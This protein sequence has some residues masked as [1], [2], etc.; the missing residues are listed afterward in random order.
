MPEKDNSDSVANIAQLHQRDYGAP[1]A[2]RGG[3]HVMSPLYLWGGALA[4]ATAIALGLSGGNAPE[5]GNTGTL[6][7]DPDKIAE[8]VSQEPTVKD[9]QAEAARMLRDG[10][11]DTQEGQARYDALQT[12]IVEEEFGPLP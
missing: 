12:S 7:A 1:K 11:L 5:T 8:P 9:M 6:P 3:E 10:E 4:T 2:P